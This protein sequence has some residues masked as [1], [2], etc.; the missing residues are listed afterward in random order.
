MGEPQR[1]MID[2]YAGITI[3]RESMLVSRQCDYL[4]VQEDVQNK[5][6]EVMPNRLK[7]WE[8]HR[9]GDKKE[10]YVLYRIAPTLPS[11]YP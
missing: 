8:G 11:D 10:N 9:P 2:Y 6:A 7:L 5:N 1:A 3:T 4:L